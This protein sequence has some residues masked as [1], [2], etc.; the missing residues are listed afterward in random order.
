MTLLPGNNTYPTLMV[1]S[2]DGTYRLRWDFSEGAV[3]HAKGARKVA[4]TSNENPDGFA[5]T[6]RLRG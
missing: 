5:L 3:A 1:D 6:A 4:A 2:I